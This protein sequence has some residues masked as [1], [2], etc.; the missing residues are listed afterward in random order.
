MVRIVREIVSM[1]RY[2]DTRARLAPLSTIEESGSAADGV[3]ARRDGAETMVPVDADDGDGRVL[4]RHRAS[5]RAFGHGGRT[6]PFLK[7]DK[8]SRG[9]TFS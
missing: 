6:L 5:R 7:A 4:G 1:G 8:L 9:L 3:V 2:A